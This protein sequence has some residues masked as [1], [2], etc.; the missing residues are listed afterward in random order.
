MA[1]TAPSTRPA[2]PDGSAAV[3]YDL[4][5]QLLEMRPIGLVREGLRFDVPFA[6]TVSG[7]RL[8]DGS[9]RGIDFFLLRPDGV[10][11]VDARMTIALADGNV[12]VHARG[13]L[14]PPE[15]L[16]M[17]PL[18]ALLDPGFAWPA[19][20]FGLQEVAYCET[21]IP[22]L[23]DLDRATSRGSGQVDM[24][25]GRVTARVRPLFD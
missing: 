6:G 4:E 14:T 3:L 10:G 25:A 24:A 17:P 15:G 5:L 22:R 19:V 13:F 23:A 16:T 12:H 21:V 18:E 20:P 9:V 1:T 8:G 7:G 2:P 11:V